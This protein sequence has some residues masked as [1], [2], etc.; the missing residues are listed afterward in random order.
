MKS[1]LIA[2]M[3]LLGNVSAVQL[4]KEDMYE[5]SYYAGLYTNILLDV[6]S[7]KHHNDQKT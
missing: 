5:P 7:F 6:D 1:G 3:A 4:R 2:V